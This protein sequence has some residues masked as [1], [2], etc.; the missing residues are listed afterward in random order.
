MEGKVHGRVAKDRTRR[1]A[2][3][4]GLLTRESLQALV[5]KEADVLVTEL[6]KGLT[7]M[8][9]DVRYRPVVLPGGAGAPLVGQVA[10]VRF[11][12]ARGVYLLGELL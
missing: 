10:R 9:R 6:G 4:A 5:G 11:A 1:A 2:T 12:G 7:L 8:G 3:L